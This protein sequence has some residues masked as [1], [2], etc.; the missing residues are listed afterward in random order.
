[1]PIIFGNMTVTELAKCWN[2][3]EFPDGLIAL[4][5]RRMGLTVVPMTQWFRWDMAW[6]PNEIRGAGG[7]LS[8]LPLELCETGVGVLP[9]QHILIFSFFGPSQRNHGTFKTWTRKMPWL[10]GQQLH[11]QNKGLTFLWFGAQEWA[12]LMNP[13]HKTPSHRPAEAVFV[14]RWSEDLP[15]QRRASDAVGLND[16]RPIAH[17]I[18]KFEQQGDRTVKKLVL[19]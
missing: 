2:A 15:V 19:S 10:L 16:G 5:M 6:S 9:K 8:I 11:W 17:S 18:W 7:S 1:M 13:D 4:G 12:P 14:T 3:W